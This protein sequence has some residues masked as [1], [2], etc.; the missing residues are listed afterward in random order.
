MQNPFEITL[1]LTPPER[2]EAE[3]LEGALVAARTLVDDAVEHRGAHRKT[4][5][6]TIVISENGTYAGVATA[7]A[8]G[9]F[10]HA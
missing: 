7:L 2:A 1:Y 4:A 10:V 9:G 6:R 8:H 3:T 5:R